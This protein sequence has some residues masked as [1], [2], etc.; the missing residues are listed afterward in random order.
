[1]VVH[2]QIEVAAAPE[3]AFAYVAD[4]TTTAEWDP[5][6]VSSER[7]SGDGGVGT[8]YAVVALFRGKEVPFR[9]RV[10]AHEPGRR[11]VLEGKGRT[12]SSTDTISFSPSGSG[13]GTRVDYEAEF[14]LHGLLALAG[15]FLAGTFRDLSAKALAGLKAQLDARA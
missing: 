14:R 9:Y 4:F 12:A 11:I 1:V 7:I 8:E 6:I 3:V 10:T 2:E 13:T 15:P 5:G